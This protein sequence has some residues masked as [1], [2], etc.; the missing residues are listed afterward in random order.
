[1]EAEVHPAGS[2]PSPRAVEH[3]ETIGPRWPEPSRDLDVPDEQLTTTL[4]TLTYRS[5]SVGLQW[6]RHLFESIGFCVL[7]LAFG[8]VVGAEHAGVV[9]LFLGSAALSSRL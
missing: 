2:I 8:H 1:M 6:P 7:G 9:S 5:V 3:R 4:A